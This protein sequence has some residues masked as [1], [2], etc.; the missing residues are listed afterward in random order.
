MSPPQRWIN[1]VKMWCV[2]ENMFLGLERD[3]VYDNVI[4]TVNKDALP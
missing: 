2:R 1:T 4:F 3:V